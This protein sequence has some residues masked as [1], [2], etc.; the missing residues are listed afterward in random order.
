[1]PQIYRAFLK[2]LKKLMIFHGMGFE[3]RLIDRLEIENSDEM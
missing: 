2:S 1:M 3:L